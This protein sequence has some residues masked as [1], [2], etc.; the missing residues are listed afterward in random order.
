MNSLTDL[1]PLTLQSTGHAES[2]IPVG[3]SNEKHGWTY[4][5]RFDGPIWTIASNVPERADTTSVA[6]L[7]YN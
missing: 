1:I 6:I 4:L 3:T 5:K 7:G 2:L